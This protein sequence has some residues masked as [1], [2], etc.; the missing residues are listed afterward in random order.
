VGFPGCIFELYPVYLAP[1]LPY[2]GFKL[3]TVV[4]A[5]VLRFPVPVYQ[6][7]QHPDDPAEPQQTTRLAD[8]FGP[9]LADG[10]DDGPFL[11]R[12]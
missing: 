7:L 4:H 5:Y 2:F 9:L 6:V 1:V 10:T 11:A 3:W 8:V 12:L